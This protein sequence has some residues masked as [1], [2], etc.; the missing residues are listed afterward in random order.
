M[1]AI[2]HSDQ[3]KLPAVGLS[4]AWL[5]V[6]P[7]DDAVLPKCVNGHDDDDKESSGDEEV[8]EEVKEE[9]HLAEQGTLD[10]ERN[11]SIDG[12]IC[13]GIDCLTHPK[14]QS[15]VSKGGRKCSLPSLFSTLAK[16]T[17][18]TSYPQNQNK[19]GIN[20]LSPPEIDLSSNL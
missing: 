10:E 6:L 11:Q 3:T 14:S 15:P 8:P 18:K 16:N 13:R 17:G 9:H 2:A 19:L 7:E 20:K 5:S 12:S 4:V 1:N